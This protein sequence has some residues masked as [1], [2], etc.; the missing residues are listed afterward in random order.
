MGPVRAGQGLL[1]WREEDR[2]LFLDMLLDA[3]EGRPFIPVP[4]PWPTHRN[5][6]AEIAEHLAKFAH[7]YKDR[8]EIADALLAIAK[9]LKNGV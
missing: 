9:D 1:T 8:P 3:G 6:D 2:E 7:Q 4:S 5:D